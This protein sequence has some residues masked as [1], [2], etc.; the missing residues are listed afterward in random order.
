MSENF[1]VIL[2]DGIEAAL[3]VG[4]AVTLLCAVLRGRA[5]A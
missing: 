5:V 4:I 1:L 3:L 2:R